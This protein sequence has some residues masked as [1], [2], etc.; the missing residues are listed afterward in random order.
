MKMEMENGYKVIYM[1]KVNDAV[2][3]AVATTRGLMPIPKKDFSRSNV[4]HN[5]VIKY[6]TGVYP[7]V[8]NLEQYICAKADAWLM[9]E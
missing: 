6:D 9:Q 4:K 3:Y 2:V 8:I 7:G 1:G 5:F